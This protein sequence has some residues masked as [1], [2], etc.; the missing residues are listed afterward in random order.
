MIYG[1]IE[2]LWAKDLNCDKKKFDLERE[3]EIVCVWAGPWR[4]RERRDSFKGPEPE[5]GARK[6]RKQKKKIGY[7]NEILQIYRLLGTRNSQAPD[8][9]IQS[10]KRWF[11]K[12]GGARKHWFHGARPGSRRPCVWEHDLACL[13]IFI[14]HQFEIESL[15]VIK[16][17]K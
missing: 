13:R 8:W 9:L 10:V 1:L 4:G 15:F 6:S 3:I 11:C 5:K 17:L 14:L 7:S 2:S 16:W 12:W